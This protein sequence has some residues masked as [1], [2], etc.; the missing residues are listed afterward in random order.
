MHHG[1]L[2]QLR[3]AASGWAADGRGVAECPPGRHHLPVATDIHDS[4]FAGRGG[5]RADHVGAV[6][7]A[8]SR[9]DSGH[10]SGSQPVPEARHTHHPAAEPPLLGTRGRSL[11]QRAAGRRRARRA[12]PAGLVREP[13]LPGRERGGRLQRVRRA[14]VGGGGGAPRVGGAAPVGAPAPAVGAATVRGGGHGLG[15]AG[16]AR[17]ARVGGHWHGAVVPACGVPHERGAV[18]A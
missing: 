18:G 14:C 5:R 7:L 3:S 17:A 8:A 13:A 2:N 4:M 10:C 16:A 9:A 6:V 1:Y 12:G 15:G 11:L